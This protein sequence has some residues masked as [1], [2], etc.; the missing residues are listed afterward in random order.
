MLVLGMRIVGRAGSGGGNGSRED[1]G[2][3]AKHRTPAGVRTGA[4]LPHVDRVAQR[5]AR[6]RPRGLRSW[7]SYVGPL[8]FAAPQG[9]EPPSPNTFPAM[10]LPNLTSA[11]L[12]AALTALSAGALSAQR[13]TTQ[14]FNLGL[15]V[16]GASLEPEGG[17]RSNAGGGGI[18]V[19]YGFNPSFQLFLQLDGAEFDVDRTEVDGRWRMGHADLGLRYH[20]AN[21]LRHWVPYLQAALSGRAVSVEDA[22]L[23]QVVQSDAVTLRGGAL[24]LG[25]GLLVYLGETFALDLQLAFSGGDFTEVE[26]GNVTVRL[27]DPYR[28]NTARFNLGVSW[29]P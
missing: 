9:G 21:A 22:V 29:W 27:S 4:T 12:L 17:E 20:F 25:G 15:H 16:S 2:V 5:V 14:G 13:S 23:N 11:L 7:T 26:A 10:R 18:F 28:A 6:N 3:S 24:T 8:I 1:R 19:G